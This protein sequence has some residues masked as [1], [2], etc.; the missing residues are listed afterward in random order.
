[1]N[2]SGLN[3]TTAYVYQWYD[4]YHYS[5]PGGCVSDIKIPQQGISGMLCCMKCSACYNSSN[6][7]WLMIGFMIA[8]WVVIGRQIMLNKHAVK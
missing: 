7:S 1:M 8:M 3:T 2:S 5:V 6:L 4:H